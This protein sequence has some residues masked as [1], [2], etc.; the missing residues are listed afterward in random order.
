MRA[1]AGPGAAGRFAVLM[2]GALGLVAC[3]SLFTSKLP[4]R[5]VYV[6]R[7]QPSAVVVALPS[8][9]TLLP[10]RVPASLDGSRIAV[11][12]PDR[13]LDE[14]SGAAWAADLDEIVQT[15]AVAS[16]RAHAG[17]HVVGL[18]SA[19]FASLYWLDLEVLDFQAEYGRAAGEPP[20]IRVRLAGTVG[21]QRRALERFEVEETQSAAG[22]RLSAIVAAFETAA[23]RALD[24]IDAGTA[25]AI[26]AQG[27]GSQ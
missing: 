17:P 20:T 4:P 21:E 18:S 7:A 15:L 12:Y 16:L 14:Y 25:E 1:A 19:P 13:R 3:G 23:N 8:D 22:N 27:R 24:R 5:S 26:A 9:L 11:L 2:G 6:L 10:P